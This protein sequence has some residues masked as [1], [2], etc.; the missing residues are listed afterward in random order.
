VFHRV[1]AV[2]LDVEAFILGAP[3]LSSS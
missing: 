2:L 1:A 3:A